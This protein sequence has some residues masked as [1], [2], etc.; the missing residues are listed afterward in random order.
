MVSLYT[1]RSHNIIK[2]W[3]LMG[4]FLILIIGL[5]FVLSRVFNAP[6]ILY[7]FVAFSFVMN[8]LSYWYSDKF[9]VAMTGAKPA[10][11][12]EYPQL[13]RTV[14]NVAMVAGLP[15]PK[16][17]VI[18]Q[19]QPNALATG[20]NPSKAIVAVTE[21]L[22]HR[23]EKQELEGVIAHEV[24]HIKNYDILVS[25]VAVVLVGV[26]SVLSDFFLR[27][28]FWFGGDDDR[29]NGGVW[30][31][32]ALAAAIIAPI[33][34]TLLQL[35]ISRRREFLADA[36]GVLLTRN[37]DGLIRALQK[38]AHDS[39]PMRN[40]S[41]ATM[42]LFFDTPV[43]TVAKRTPWWIKIFLTHPPVE[44][45]VAALHGRIV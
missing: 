17:Y 31:V 3:L 11:K 29:R 44:D 22:L 1:V 37:P 38:I 39:T 27:M 19:L 13:Y 30:I 15:T 36:S 24:S 7:L 20:R 35:G 33:A 16:I 28:S 21:G 12:D 4:V 8:A 41:S 32:L 40:V 14:E 25:T 18:P 45:R 9:V 10:T 2:T 23:L 34:A 26:I 6:E 5:G 43:K 42:H